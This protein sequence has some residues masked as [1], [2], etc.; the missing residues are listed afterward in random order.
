MGASSGAWKVQKVW[1]LPQ[2]FAFSHNKTP[3]AE[4]MS[5]ELKDRLASAISS[6]VTTAPLAVAAAVLAVVLSALAMGLFS[7]NNHFKPAGKVR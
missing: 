1:R 7:R 3:S 4:R 6:V 5:A 2:R